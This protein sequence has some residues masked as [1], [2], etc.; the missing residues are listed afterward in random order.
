M[1]LDE[2]VQH[3]NNWRERN[4]TITTGQEQAVRHFGELFN[5]SRLQQLT[6]EEF[7]AF[8]LFKNNKHWTGIHR[9]AGQITADM[10]KLRSAL[11][12]LLNESKPLAERLNTLFPQTGQPFIR[13]LGR[14][15]VTPI[16]MVVH[17]DKYGVYN[18]ISEAGLQKLGLLPR[19]KSTDPFSR[20]YAAVN[21]VLL[22]IAH[23]RALPLP[24]VDV[25]FFQVVQDA[26]GPPGGREAVNG[27]DNE[28]ES[29]EAAS[30]MFALEKH[31]EDFLIENWNKTILAEQLELYEEDGDIAQQYG[32]DVGTIDILARDRKNKDWVVLELKR[33]QD[34]D[35][36]L[37]Q[38]LRYMG[39]IKQRKAQ[40]GQNVRG[41]I[42]AGHSDERLE[43]ALQ[44][45]VGVELYLYSVD[46][47]LKRQNPTP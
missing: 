21:D 9:Q 11:E 25:M 8:L 2:A 19:I 14:A 28:P 4:P 37:G 17:P 33:G 1:T 13:G 35:K 3:L 6:R 39:W 5:P 44:A 12:I 27:D 38:V 23:N 16:L 10:E 30:A 36:A 20:R 34:S 26:D 40:P 43:Y 46:F 29:E 24:F 18:S 22:D 7:R 47:R 15:V 31:L 42:V 41:I 32:T 45:A